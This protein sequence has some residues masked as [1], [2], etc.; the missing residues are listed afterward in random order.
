MT[1]EKYTKFKEEVERR[2][3]QYVV[4]WVAGYDC[5]LVNGREATDE[6]CKKMFDYMLEI[7]LFDD[8]IAVSGATNLTKEKRGE[9]YTEYD[10]EHMDIIIKGIPK[11]KQLAAFWM[12]VNRSTM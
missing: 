2:A 10:I 11:I 8:Y 7:E 1:L 6:Y 5:C 3:R 4:S 12:A 9:S